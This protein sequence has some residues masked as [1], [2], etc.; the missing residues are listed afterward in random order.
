MRDEPVG[1]RGGPRA[2]MSI[3]LP[4]HWSAHLGAKHNLPNICD[5][6]RC[7]HTCK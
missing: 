2:L 6:E 5:L 7:Q 3:L 1:L 4:V